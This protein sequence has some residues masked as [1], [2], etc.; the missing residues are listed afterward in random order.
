MTD[1]FFFAPTEYP[2]G[3]DRATSE[4]G[5]KISIVDERGTKAKVI[6][7]WCDNVLG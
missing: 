1:D 5:C 2:L 6:R 7:Y 4:I 3:V